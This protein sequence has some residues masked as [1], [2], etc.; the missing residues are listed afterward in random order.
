MPPRSKKQEQLDEA[1]IDDH[2][3]L[4]PSQRF[5]AINAARM[6]KKFPKVKHAT[7]A[8]EGNDALF[9]TMPDLGNQWAL[10][11]PGY[12]MGRVCYILGEEGTSKTSRLLYKCGLALK[13]GGLAAI[14]EWEDAMDPDH[15]SYYLGDYADQLVIHHADSLEQGMEMSRE[16]LRQFAE[17]DPEG[18]LVKVLGADSVG[19]S[20]MERALDDER[21]IGDARVGGTGLYMG[22][23]VPLLK[24]QCARTNTLWVVLGQLREKIETGF[25]GPP[26]AYLEKVTGKG[27]KSLPFEATYWEILQ[28]GATLKDGDGAKDGFRVRST[29]KKNKKGVQW[30][31][32]SYDIEFY[33]NL[34]GMVP[35]MEMLSIGSIC[36]LKSKAGGS[37]GKKYWVEGLGQSDVE[38]GKIDE[39][40]D[41]IHQPCNITMF[42]DALGIRRDMSD[43]P[44]TTTNTDHEPEVATPVPVTTETT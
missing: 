20:V 41:L 14:V 38:G 44:D 34:S 5:L 42:Q 24:H 6:A 10:S 12:A 36:G 25:S 16:V 17:I 21:E 18:K 19:G 7:G 11:R 15:I 4:T 33:K 8:S 26:K 43:I 32:Y 31:E 28:R 37:K 1:S 2:S 35:T 22:A 9:L 3:Q 29:F 39:I 27:G 30:R 40:Y 23:A 13:A